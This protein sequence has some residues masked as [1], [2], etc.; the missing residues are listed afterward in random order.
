MHPPWDH[1]ANS[2]SQPHEFHHP[3]LTP[4]SHPVSHIE[5]LSEYSH[6]AL[7]RDAILTPQPSESVV[8]TAVEI[9]YIIHRTATRAR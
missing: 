8:Y 3:R 9:K 4:L 1:H 7:A 5:P 2:T 6:A